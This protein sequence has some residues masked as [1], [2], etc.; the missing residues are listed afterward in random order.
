MAAAIRRRGSF[1]GRNAAARPRGA[2]R[3]RVRSAVPTF[4]LPEGRTRQAEGDRGA[5]EIAAV[6]PLAGGR[7]AGA[8]VVYRRHGTG[9]QTGARGRARAEGRTLDPAGTAARSQRQRR[10]P[11]PRATPLLSVLVPGSCPFHF[12]ACRWAAWLNG[13]GAMSKTVVEFVRM[14]CVAVSLTVA[15][16]C[17]NH[18]ARRHRRHRAQKHGCGQG[19]RS[20]TADRRRAGSES[21]DLAETCAGP[22]GRDRRRPQ[23]RA[24]AANSCLQMK[25]FMEQLQPS[26]VRNA[27]HADAAQG[28]VDPQSLA[29]RA[30]RWSRRFRSICRC[31]GYEPIIN[32]VRPPRRA[33]R[34]PEAC[35]ATN[36]ARTCSPTS[37]TTTSRRSA[38]APS[39]R[40]CWATSQ[41][42]ASSSTITRCPACCT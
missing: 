2:R 24:A 22:R 9:T 40:T 21:L 30:S 39:A 33:R 11:R 15:P 25:T 28:L 42:P 29:A 32:A 35:D 6:L 17:A 7:V 31:T 23:E 10:A 41:R 8:R 18:L 36:S 20:G 13:K 1:L 26:A 37:A 16:I 38:R 5:D 12:G 34:R 27:G 4:P 19:T 14:E 3:W